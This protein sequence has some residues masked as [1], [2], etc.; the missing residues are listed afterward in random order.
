MLTSLTNF[1]I[2]TN[3]ADPEQSDLGPYCLSQKVLNGLADDT[4]HDI[5][6][7]KCQENNASENVVC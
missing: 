5:E 1:G 4:P 3:I 2:Q 7:L 6:L